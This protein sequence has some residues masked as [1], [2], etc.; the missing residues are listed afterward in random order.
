[1]KLQWL[2]A[3]WMVWATELELGMKNLCLFDGETEGGRRSCP[4]IALRNG[5]NYGR[6]L[7]STWRS[8]TVGCGF[9]NLCIGYGVDGRMTSLGCP[10]KWIPP[11]VFCYQG[12]PGP[13]LCLLFLLWGRSS[14][15]ENASTS[16]CLCIFNFHFSSGLG[17][18]W[19]LWETQFH[20]AV[21]WFQCFLACTQVEHHKEEA[22]ALWSCL[23]HGPGK[24]CGCKEEIE[25]QGGR[26]ERRREEK[27]RTS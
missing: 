26:D 23:P 16:L 7:L 3:K 1:M 8:P 21:D 10:R 2:Q 5:L 24:H 19:T 15:E 13:L 14:S 27:P 17:S 20:L 6:D 9:K 25:A 22:Q 18:F 4:W 11:E 12:K